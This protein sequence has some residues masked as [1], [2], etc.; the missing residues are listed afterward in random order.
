MNQM[1]RF[2]NFS[3]KFG[4]CGTETQNQLEAKTSA[5][6]APPMPNT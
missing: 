4:I 3:P 5:F 1:Y 2:T 6:P